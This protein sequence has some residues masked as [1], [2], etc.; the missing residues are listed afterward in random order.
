MASWSTDWA[1][2]VSCLLLED[3]SI[4]NSDELILCSVL[5]WKGVKCEIHVANCDDPI[6]AL[7]LMISEIDLGDPLSAVG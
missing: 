5:I 3:G 7:D 4:S 2:E 6:L 1:T